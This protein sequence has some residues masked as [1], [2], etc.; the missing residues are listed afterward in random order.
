MVRS[1][2]K[3]NINRLLTQILASQLSGTLLGMANS[4]ITVRRETEDIVGL[5]N[6]SLEVEERGIIDEEGNFPKS[7]HA[8]VV[9][10]M[11]TMFGMCESLVS[12]NQLPLFSVC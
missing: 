4:I 2:T 11:A 7:T 8:F 3:L 5:R 12:I 6:Q 10:A 9:D 1:L